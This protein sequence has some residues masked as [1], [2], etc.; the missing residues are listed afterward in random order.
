MGPAKT[1]YRDAL[2][3]YP[4]DE[5]NWIMWS[6]DVLIGAAAMGLDSI[7]NGEETIIVDSYGSTKVSPE[8]NILLHKLMALLP[9]RFKLMTHNKINSSRKMGSSKSKLR[10]KV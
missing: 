1:S 6:N 4:L 3:S 2:A 8:N 7:L 10:A 5:S 9:Q